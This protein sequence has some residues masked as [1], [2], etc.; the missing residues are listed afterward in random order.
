MLPIIIEN[1]DRP[2]PFGESNIGGIDLGVDQHAGVE[3]LAV[4]SAF[5]GILDGV[6]GV[7]DNASPLLVEK[8]PD[9]GEI[10]HEETYKDNARNQHYQRGAKIATALCK[11]HLG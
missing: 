3:S 5:A 9:V 8:R 10:G 1:H 7:R 2:V 6:D 4:R 11:P